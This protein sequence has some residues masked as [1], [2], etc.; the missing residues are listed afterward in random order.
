MFISIHFKTKILHYLTIIISA[1]NGNTFYLRLIFVFSHANSLHM[2]LHI[3]YG[4][5]FFLFRISD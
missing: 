1:A 5:W 4:K 3:Q 2:W